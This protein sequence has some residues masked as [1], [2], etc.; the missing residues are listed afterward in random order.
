[1]AAET[2]QDS[3]QREEEE[4]AMRKKFPTAAA[5]RSVL[6]EKRLS[7]GGQQYFDSGDYNL[8]RA[9]KDPKHKSKLNAGYP[10]AMNHS[11]TAPKSPGI[12]PAGALSPLTFC[13][14]NPLTPLSTPTDP[15]TTIG[16][17]RAASITSEQT[18]RPPSSIDFHNR[19]LS[20]QQSRLASEIEAFVDASPDAAST[21]QP[22]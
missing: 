2:N 17:A 16:I 8:A 6:L 18:G 5:G 13:P 12:L 9:A 3:R 15:G 20:R 22:A 10:L 1:M 14:V 7:R 21:E 11:S 19:R 4:A